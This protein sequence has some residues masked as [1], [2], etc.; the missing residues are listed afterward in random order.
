MGS[1][2]GRFKD[3]QRASEDRAGLRDALLQVSRVASVAKQ[4]VRQE[5]RLKGSYATDWL[6]G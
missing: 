3:W 5:T 4:S 6:L 1:L 2:E